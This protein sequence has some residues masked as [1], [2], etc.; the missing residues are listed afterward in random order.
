MQTRSPFGYPNADTGVE[1][2]D[3][4]LA[5]LRWVD[6]REVEEV[7]EGFSFFGAVHDFDG[8]FV[9]AEVETVGA[10]GEVGIEHGLIGGVEPARLPEGL[11]GVEV[12]ADFILPPVV[13]CLDELEELKDAVTLF[14]RAGGIGGPGIKGIWRGVVRVAGGGC[15]IH[16]GLIVRDKAML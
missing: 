4:K 7:A 2:R 14:E 16:A 5:L 9:N 15:H 10:P 12:E 11:V 8:V 3:G 13:A 1:A 6:G